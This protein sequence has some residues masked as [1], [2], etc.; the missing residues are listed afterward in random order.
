V[1]RRGRAGLL[2][3]MMFA[4][5]AIAVLSVGQ[6]LQVGGSA[7]FGVLAGVVVAVVAGGLL[8]LASAPDRR[9]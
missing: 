8:V 9:R 3:L 5:I 7:W 4:G 6:A 2:I 1:E